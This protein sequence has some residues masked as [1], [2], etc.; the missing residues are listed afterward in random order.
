MTEAL[1]SS[2][3]TIVWNAGSNIFTNYTVIAGCLGGKMTFI[4]N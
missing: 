4:K 3:R 2:P 1:A